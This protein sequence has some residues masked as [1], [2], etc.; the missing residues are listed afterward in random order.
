MSA[1]EARTHTDFKVADLSLADFGRKETRAT[2]PCGA[3]EA[4]AHFKAPRR[5]SATQIRRGSAVQLHFA[6]V[7]LQGR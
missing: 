4:R 2:R 7:R 6:R 3:T 5:R 1:T